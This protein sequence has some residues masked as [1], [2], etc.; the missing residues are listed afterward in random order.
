MSNFVET[1]TKVQKHFD[2]EKMEYDMN[3]LKEYINA[4]NTMVSLPE[5]DE[6]EL[7]TFLKYC[8][9][10][11]LN[12]LFKEIYL[13]PMKTKRG[14]KNVPV[15]AYQEYIKRAS[16]NP[17]YQLPETEVVLHD[18]NGNMLPKDKIYVV[19][20]AKRKGDDSVLQKVYLMSEWMKPTSPVWMQSPVEMLQIRA[21]KNILA[22][23]YPE[24]VSVLENY[25]VSGEVAVVKD[26]TNELETNKLKQLI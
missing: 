20:R 5:M 3:K 23:A 13:V 12:P 14:V 10:L 24:E 9:T 8:F 11:K 7:Y 22:I 21:I 19:A 16:R 6:I 26:N 18:S 17:K 25:E 4:L 2:N 1:L 15:I